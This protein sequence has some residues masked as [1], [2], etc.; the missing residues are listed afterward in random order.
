MRTLLATLVLLPITAGAAD[1]R[2]LDFDAGCT[3]VE[4]LEVAA[5]SVP[6]PWRSPEDGELHAFRG[7]AFDREVSIVY[8]CVDGKLFTGNYFFPDEPLEEAA[9]SY[10]R[11][12]DELNALYGAP[13]LDDTPWQNGARNPLI[14]PRHYASW[15][16]SGLSVY[17]TLMRRT[18]APDSTRHVFVVFSRLRT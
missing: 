12:Y 17:A 10:R 14:K 18:G 11:I 9:E 1:F 3:E 15:R 6:I 13:F 7:R 2:F 4:K 16:T 8:F 5:G